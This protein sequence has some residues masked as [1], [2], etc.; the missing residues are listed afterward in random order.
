[1]NKRCIAYV[2]SAVL[3]LAGCQSK[4]QEITISAAAS[5]TDV[6]EEVVI[7]FEQ[8]YPSI[9]ISLNLGGSGALSQQIIQGAPA[10]IFLSASI[11]K[12]DLVRHEGLLDGQFIQPLVMNKLVWIQ[13]KGTTSFKTIDQ[14]NRI[15][16]GTPESVPAGKYAKE[17]FTDIEI[18]T[19]L[20]SKFVYTKD[21]RQVL[22]YV[23]TENV[24]AGIVYQTDAEISEAV[25]INKELPLG[26]YDPIIYPVG[27]LKETQQKEA[28]ETFY[29]FLQTEEVIELFKQYGF[30]EIDGDID[31]S[32][33][34]T[35]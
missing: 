5:L 10:D 28:A 34:S 27:I 15:A 18:F 2:L 11:D 13:A 7:L 24:D 1:M 16:I 21:V 23:E 31:G 12:F 30:L 6:L 8:E 4:E 9:Q 3:L 22:Q 20:E 29:R 19:K 32:I 33:F 17:A 14:I 25:Q 26:E 35:N